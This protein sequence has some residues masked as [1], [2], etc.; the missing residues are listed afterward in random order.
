MEAIK[1]WSMIPDVSI[2]Y[3]VYMAGKGWG[4]T[5]CDGAQAGT[6]GESRRIEAMH[7]WSPNLS[8]SQ[9]IEYQSHLEDR[10]WV[11]SR[12]DG[13]VTGTTGE[14]R[15]LEAIRI[16]LTSRRTCPD[17][18]DPD[19]SNPS[20][21]FGNGWLLFAGKSGE[22]AWGT[23]SCEGGQVGFTSGSTLWV[24][25][26]NNDFTRRADGWTTVTT[27]TGSTLWLWLDRLNNV[28]DAWF[29]NGNWQH[30]GAATKYF[31]GGIP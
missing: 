6:T 4:P 2:C 23:P 21:R 31:A 19:V 13:T 15:R 29:H 22:D 14:S 8:P 17:T 10:G 30:I 16:Y 28:A 5:V 26:L 24:W 20:Y 25:N 18:F 12:Y 11:M 27:T 3:K 9:S 7:I 1:I